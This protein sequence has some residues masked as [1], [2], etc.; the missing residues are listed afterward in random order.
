MKYTKQIFPAYRTDCED[1]SNNNSNGKKRLTPNKYYV[2]YYIIL[3][4]INLTISLNVLHQY[5][6]IRLRKIMNYEKEKKI[7]IWCLFIKTCKT[8]RIMCVWI[9]NVICLTCQTET[10][11][12]SFSV[13]AVLKFPATWDN[14]CFYIDY[15]SA[16][17]T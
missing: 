7:D 11:K 5:V 16:I 12:K 8:I 13:T 17:T 1:N 14:R 3:Y 10:L 15:F 6:I 9:Y 4:Y 2:N